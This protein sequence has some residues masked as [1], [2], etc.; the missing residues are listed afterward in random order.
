MEQRI[1]VMGKTYIIPGN[2]VS[3]LI[4]WLESNAVE[5]TP[6]QVVR[7]ITGDNV[8]PRQLLTEDKG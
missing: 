5:N 6:R 2:R 4:S 7:E 8:D 1:T 3:S